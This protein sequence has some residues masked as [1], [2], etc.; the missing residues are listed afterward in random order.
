MVNKYFCQNCLYLIIIDSIQGLKSD[1]I[2]QNWLRF[3][4]VINFFAR[5]QS[6]KTQSLDPGKIDLWRPGW[7][8]HE[9]WV[10]DWLDNGQVIGERLADTL[11]VMLSEENLGQESEQEDG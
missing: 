10:G 11:G 2:Y 7:E 3:E 4:R 6:L 1:I 9:G 5:C 8:V